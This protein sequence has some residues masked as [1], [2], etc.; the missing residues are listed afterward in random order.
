VAPSRHPSHALKQGA[1]TDLS[2]IGDKSDQRLYQAPTI[3]LL[4]SMRGRCRNSARSQRLSLCL[5]PDDGMQIGFLTLYLV[6]R[7]AQRTE[8]IFGNGPV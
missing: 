6:E 5:L 8:P 3:E 4:I 2:P 7:R 1:R